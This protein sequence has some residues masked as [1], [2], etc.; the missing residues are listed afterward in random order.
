MF[1]GSNPLEWL[2]QTSQFSEFYQLPPEN[3][4][5][6][7][8]FYMKGEA[9]CWFKW[10]HQSQLLLDW[11]SFTKAL[12]LCFDPSSTYAYHQAELFKLKQVSQVVVYQT[13]FEN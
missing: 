3:R 8:S 13:K 2:F 12:E 5:S 11:P 10:M 9:L 7:M 4:I 1:D 6:M